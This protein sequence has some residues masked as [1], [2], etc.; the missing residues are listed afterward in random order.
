[1]A[2]QAAPNVFLDRAPPI[3]SVAV[4]T[5]PS[6]VMAIKKSNQHYNS[7]VG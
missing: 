4:A 2:Y 6:V 3:N 5:K 7:V 1:M